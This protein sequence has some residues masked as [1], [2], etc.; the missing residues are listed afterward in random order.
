MTERISK[1]LK[2]YVCGAKQRDADQRS[3][4]RVQGMQR[5]GGACWVQ[6]ISA[7]L[8][9]VVGFNH[10]MYFIGI[11][12]AFPFL[13]Q[14]IFHLCNFPITIDFERPKRTWH[15]ASSHIPILHTSPSPLKQALHTPDPLHPISNKQH[16]NEF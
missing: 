14:C 5:R 12:H 13:S 10:M 15:A 6:I 7:P 1:L 3:R 2:C 4:K 9:S 16:N 8:W 11:F